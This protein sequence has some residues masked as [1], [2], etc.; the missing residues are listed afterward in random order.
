MKSIRFSTISLF[1][2]LLLTS[3]NVNDV[4]AQGTIN[5]SPDVRFSWS[6]PIAYDILIDRFANGNPANDR[7]YGRGTD[8][9]GT[10]Y[11]DSG[12]EYFTGGDLAGI[13]QRIRQG[14]FDSLGVN[15]LL[16][17]PPFEQVHG[18]VPSADGNAGRYGYHGEWPLDFTSIDANWGTT[19][20]FAELVQTAH[21]RNIRVV[22][23]VDLTRA[24]PPTLADMDLFGFGAI[25][26]SSDWGN[27]RPTANESWAGYVE[28]FATF[29][30]STVTDWA[31]WWGPEWVRASLPG[32]DSCSANEPADCSSGEA[33]FKL[34]AGATVKIPSF[35]A[36]KWGENKLAAESKSLAQFFDRSGLSATPRNHLIKWLTDWV[37]R[38]GV[39]GFRV[40]AAG[41]TIEGAL[42]ELKRQSVVAR[43]E[44]L[45]SNPG[46][47]DGD[48]DF[49]MI[50]ESPA[51]PDAGSLYQLGFD[52]LVRPPF[53][54]A[55]DVSEL[56]DIYRLL[57]E[58]ITASD[59]FDIVNRLSTGRSDLTDESLQELVT[60]FMLSP[61]GIRIAYGEETGGTT[62]TVDSSVLKHWQTLGQ[63]RQ[64]HPSLAAGSH[65]TL[66][67]SP[68]T[69]IRQ[70][71]NPSVDDVV[72]V[73]VGASG[74]TRI[75][76][77]R[78]FPDDAV[79]RDVV[80]GKTAFVSFGFATFTAA[81]SGLMLL[82]LAD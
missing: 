73:A 36:E 44:W 60:Q 50:A 42:E 15:V 9:D 74:R 20:E 3:L 10:A 47:L 64:R 49:W 54:P 43:N 70:L 23:D 81:P 5:A 12:S 40:A 4:S 22:F 52:A 55:K 34:S 62:N 82:E 45:A 80:T 30:D 58:S 48:T 38:Y 18:F 27:W 32:Y 13:T 56:E 8:R 51:E 66:S 65:L 75:N 33:A 7:S 41:V 24:G 6:N 17:S 14:Y 53:V 46:L 57:S 71:R 67:S 2:A 72:V 79:V 59:G 61:G 29:D 69:F 28:R 1:A 77:S 68:Y 39:D 26:D 78:A 25:T 21:A 76:V 63:F 35:L 16:L 11:E 37:R 19:E 31:R